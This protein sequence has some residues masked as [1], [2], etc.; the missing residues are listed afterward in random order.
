MQNDK[1]RNAATGSVDEKQSDEQTAATGSDL[2]RQALEEANAD[3][4]EDPDLSEG[5]ESDDLDEG[6]LARFES[7]E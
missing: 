2:N 7:G 4:S 1:N 5:D 3:I 6:E